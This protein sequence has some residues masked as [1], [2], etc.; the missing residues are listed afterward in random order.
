M[1]HLGDALGRRG[2]AGSEGLEILHGDEGVLVGGELV[3]DVV[4]DETGE[5][6]PLGQV[7]AEEAHLVHLA[8][9]LGHAP[10]APADVE[11]EIAH[12]HGAAEAVVHEVER[13]FDGAVDVHP[14]LESQTVGMPEHLHEPHRLGA[15]VA[16]V[17]VDEVDALVHHEQAVGQRLL[18]QPAQHGAPPGQRLL[19]AGDE[20]ARHTVD[21]TG[22]EVVVAHELL[23]VQRVLVALVAEALGDLGLEI[24][25]EH[26]VL[27]SREKVELVADAPQKGEAASV[28][29]SSLRVIRPFSRRSRSVRAPNLVEASHIAVWRSRSPRGLLHVGLAHVRRA[30]ELPVALIALGER[31][32]EELAEVL[33]VD[34][35]REDPAE[36]LEEPPVPTT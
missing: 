6:V 30:A 19:A 17:G 10:P 33:A 4:L 36:A 7:A 1:Q 5:G 28:S 31:G 3:I 35:L 9:R 34:V 32:L 11:E 18:A 27:V 20:P 15:E 16:P 8:K 24:A 22:V 21:D 12:L 29:R 2:G 23:D 14:Q 25:R 13:L 26:V